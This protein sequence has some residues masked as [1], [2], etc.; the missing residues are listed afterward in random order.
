MVRF[1]T[2]SLRRLPA[3]K[4]GQVT[5]RTE[6]AGIVHAPIGLASFTEEQLVANFDA[7][8]ESVKKAKPAAAK[9]QYLVAASLS[10]TMGP[11]VHVD[12]TSLR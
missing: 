5:Y 2:T 3:P 10:S 4:A 12:I 9:G 1:P 6:K 8:I 11:S 7:L